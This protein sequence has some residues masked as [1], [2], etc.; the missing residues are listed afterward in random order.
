MI[1]PVVGIDSPAQLDSLAGQ[2]VEEVIIA[3]RDFSR[4][5]KLSLAE[6]AE[7]S[8]AARRKGT[9]PLLQ[10]DLLMTETVLRK[11]MPLLRQLLE[12]GDFCALRVQ[13]SGALQWGLEETTLPLHL[14]VETGNHNLSGLQEWGRLMGKRLERL[15]LSTQI[16]RKQLQLYGKKLGHPLELLGLGPILL[17]Y[18]PRHLLEKFGQVSKEEMG[19]LASS[20]ESAHKNFSVLSNA[21]GTFLFHQKHH[22]L[23]EHVSDLAAMGITHLRL[24]APSEDL[25]R[26]ALEL[27]RYPDQTSLE[28]FRVDY[29]SP[30]IRGFYHRNKST[31]LFSKLKNQGLERFREQS[32]GEVIGVEKGHFLGVQLREGRQLRVGEQ[33][34]IQT[35]EG[36]SISFTLHTLKGPDLSSTTCIVGGLA[37]VGHVKGVGPKGLVLPYSNSDSF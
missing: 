6:G 17:F 27:I 19:M 10:W 28:D 35:P 14:I 20:E 32:I 33:Y 24:E 36:R 4:W 23:L 37:L 30:L 5:G 12:E 13:D 15:V 3:V 26:R 18:T 21:H 11:K 2:G 25:L 31:V 9:R 34:Q 8:R 22:W 1:A 29:P 7:L 16:P